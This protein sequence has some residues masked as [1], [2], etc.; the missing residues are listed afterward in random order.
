MIPVGIVGLFS[1][2]RSRSC[3][4]RACWWSAA[5]V[6]TAILLAFAYYAQPRLKGNI[7]FKRCFYRQSVAQAFTRS[8]PGLSRSGST[9]R[10]RVTARRPERPGRPLFRSDGADSD[11]G[12]SVFDLIERRLPPFRNR[13][14]ALAL[15]AGFV[16]ALSLGGLFACSWMI[17]IVKKG[18]VDLFRYCLIVG[19]VS[20]LYSVI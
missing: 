12:R 8:L 10:Y 18:Q 17:N 1:R 6:L 13:V 15:T 16:T 5:R 7:S 3:S 19:T 2:I 4:R 9:V 20:I 11:S 14:S